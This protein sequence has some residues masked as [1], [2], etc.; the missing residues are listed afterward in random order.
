[1]KLADADIGTI[2]VSAR[3]IY[4]NIAMVSTSSDI[5][6]VSVATIPEKACVPYVPPR[7]NCKNCGAPLRSPYG[8]E[9]CGTVC[10]E[11]ERYSGIRLYADGI[12][13]FCGG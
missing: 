8:C 5:C 6:P 4:D 7:S 10:Q 13:I 9:Y 1:M 12:E 3:D 2:T 11:S